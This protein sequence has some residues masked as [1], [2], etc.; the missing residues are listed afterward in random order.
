M[1]M[2]FFFQKVEAHVRIPLKFLYFEL[3]QRNF[4]GF[5]IAIP[6]IKI[7]IYGNFLLD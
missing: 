7:T 3:I 4:I 5:L 1:Q 2:I 6:L